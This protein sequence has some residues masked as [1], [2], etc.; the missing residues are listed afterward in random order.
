MNERKKILIGDET[1]D[2]GMIYQT[3]L[4]EKGYKVILTK[5]DGVELF[6]A[7]ERER[8]YLVIMNAIMTGIDA[9][10]LLD[11]VKNTDC[12]PLFIVTSA[13]NNAMIEKQIMENDHCYYILEPFESS[14]LLD[15]VDKMCCGKNVTA[16]HH[17]DYTDQEQLQLITDIIQQI[18]VPAHIKG[19]HYLREA[20]Q[21]SIQDTAL[22]SSVTKQLYP[23]VAKH[24]NTTASR[25]ERAIRHAIEVA[26]DRG[27]VDILNSY[28]GYTI[29]NSRGKPTNSEFIAMIAD[30]IRMKMS[31]GEKPT[32]DIN[33]KNR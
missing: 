19:Y 3:R 9:C 14:M 18:G 11:N 25:V 20:I 13:C 16:T 29:Q 31:L 12:Y 15:R 21:F 33:N 8:P 26:W 10:H 2:F 22:M 23:V 17:M 30:K 1:A 7:I 28:F 32:I 4:E 27:D 5:R 6:K 24:F